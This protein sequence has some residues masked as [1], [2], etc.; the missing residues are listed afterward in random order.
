MSAACVLAADVGG[1][2]TRVLLAESDGATCTPLR[3]QHYVSADWPDLLPI[4]ENFL[5][6]ETRRP[7]CACLA[8]AGPITGP[9]SSPVAGPI[10][11][12]GDGP[13]HAHVTN[14]PWS[15][16]SDTLAQ[17]LNIPRLA[18]INDFAAVGHGIAA[19]NADDLLTL[20]AGE[21]QPCAP[22]AVLGAGTGLGQ[23][24][25]VWR[26]GGYDVL[27]T[28]GGH[29]DFAPQNDQQVRLLNSLRALHGHV[30]CERLCSG[31]GLAYIY[32]FLQERRG[33]A[34]PEAIAQAFAQPSDQASSPSDPAA[35]ISQAALAGSDAL[36]Q[37]ALREFVRIYGAQAG[38]LALSC[39]PF[40]GLY[41]AGGIAPKILPALTDGEFLR[42]FNAKGRMEKLTR[43][44]PLH[45]VVHPT[46]G[47]L[48]AAL[49]AGR[50]SPGTAAGF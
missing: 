28:E 35:A 46:P 21:P 26:D 38:N 25:L 3:E 29:M 41:V 17:C 9:I 34:V 49:Y 2:H 4:L 43:R 32:R 39:L 12:C 40:A 47:L 24:L 23:A 20:Q 11:D 31:S 5:A 18:L 10:K 33:A 14:L 15:L 30:S 7:A 45:I 8:I 16:A 13:Q 1:T 42:A 37:E 6:A 48:G 19:L 50:L 27:S 36:A 22:R 44:I